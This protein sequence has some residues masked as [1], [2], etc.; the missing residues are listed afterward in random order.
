MGRKLWHQTM[1]IDRC[2][3]VLKTLNSVFNTL[4]YLLLILAVISSR[5]QYLYVLDWDL[6]FPHYMLYVPCLLCL[7]F[8]SLL[9]AYESR[10][11]SQS[12]IERHLCMHSQKAAIYW[13]RSPTTHWDINPKWSDQIKSIDSKLRWIFFPQVCAICS[14]PPAL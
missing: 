4:L 1:T 10:G 7:F 8:V 13:V 3:A 2:R 9:S 6:D 12:V 14:A 5:Y 11:W